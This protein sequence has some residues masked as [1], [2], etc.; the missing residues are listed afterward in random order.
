MKKHLLLLFSFVA[1]TITGPLEAQEYR[2]AANPHYWANRKPY[3]GY[4]QQDVNYKIKANIDEVSN[5]IEGDLQLEYFNNSPDTLSE[6]Y[7]HLYQNAFQPGSYLDDLQK[8][9][10]V[11][12]R[13]GRYEAEKKGTEVFSVKTGNES[14]TPEMDNTIMKIKLPKALLPGSSITFNIQ[15]KTYFDVGNTRRRMKV[16]NASGYKHY[17]GV[18]WYPRISVYD[19]KFGWDTQQHLG[20]EFYGDFGQY[21]VE[22]TFSSNYVVEA[23]G[24]LQNQNEVFPGDL[25][26][27]LDISNFANKPWESKA[28]EITPYNKAERKTWKYKA[29]NVHDF[30]FTADPTYRIGEVEWNGIK[31]IAVV[32]EG[33]AS[34]WQNAAAYTAKIVETYSRDFGMYL[35]PKM[36]VADARDGMEYPM[37]TLDGGG[38]PDYRGLFAH[39]VGHNWFFGMVGNNE[40]YRAMMDEGFTQFLTSWALEHLDGDT[41]PS[42]PPKGFYL[43][44]FK[45]RD[46][47][48]ESRVYNAY[49]NDAIRGNDTPLNVH[50]DD[51][52]GA[53][54][55]GGGYRNVYYKTASMLYNLQYVLGDELFLAAMKN[56]FNQWKICHPYPEDFRESIIRYTKVDL[57]WFFDQW[58]ETT[59]TIDYKIVCVKNKGKKKQTLRI[60]RK[61][62]MQM[63]L[64]LTIVCKND[65]TYNFHIP[66]TEFVKK[67]SGQSLGKWLGWGKL[68][69]TYTAE[70]NLG[71]KIKSVQIDSSG[72]MADTDLRNNQWPR[73]TS[74]AFDSRV[75]NAPNRFQYEWFGRPEVW[76]NAYDG[77]KAGIHLNGNYMN[78][79]NIFEG[80]FWFNFGLIQNVDSALVP[81]NGYDAFSF[82]IQYDTPIKAGGKD[83]R[84]KT[85]IRNLDGLQLYQ[86][87][88]ERLLPSQKTKWYAYVKSMYRKNVNDLQYLLY[89]SQWMADRWNNTLNVG[90]EHSYAY[91]R[92]TG[93]I[94]LNLRT[95]APYSDYSYS[96]ITFTVVNKNRLGKFDFN[97]R[98]FLQL[99]FGSDTPLESALYAAGANPEELMENKYTRSIG[100]IPG[101]WAGYGN[102]FNH[103]HHSGGM[104]LRGYSGYLMPV[105]NQYDLQESAFT[106]P[107]GAAVNLELAFDRLL[108][109]RKPKIHETFDFD[110]YLFTDAGLMGIGNLKQYQS[111]DWV[112]NLLRVD[113]GFGASLSIKKWGG[114]QKVSPLTIRADFPVFVNATPFLEAT[115]FAFRW[116]IGVSKTF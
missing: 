53:L 23:T 30:A 3:P 110:S 7:F 40:T 28:S 112:G 25:R 73:K 97:S 89:Q 76:W 4:W 43:K 79:K 64:D 105:Y 49:M 51:F 33:H 13:Y 24:E 5:I 114:I 108:N 101:E 39:E 16:F 27:R 18:H 52:N 45:K 63:P 10:G 32:Q 42:S 115:N 88:I 69:P 19:H 116:L 38:D 100:F 20:K 92:G 55:H 9:N 15:F 6:V 65:S 1:L 67:H 62:E 22:L 61:G 12:P 106:I 34:R 85:K 8:E 68:K 83:V 80:T 2:S 21:E 57:N 91:R 90:L 58:I 86:L 96:Q 77:L 71:S 113:A 60:E 26:Q 50:S 29:I 44:R 95:A 75:I 37:L 87:G 99:G 46:L 78:H 41:L 98:T 103:F 11:R 35:Y 70:F 102:Q 48:R 59:K 107:S 17:D 31:M 81:I 109:I 47:T 72:R 104:N 111:N 93:K 74:F 94:N 84:L 82:N 14:L 54:G 66:N 56:Y 36:V